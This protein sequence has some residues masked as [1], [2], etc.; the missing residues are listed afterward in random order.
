VQIEHTADV[1]VDAEADSFQGLLEELAQAMFELIVDPGKVRVGREYDVGVISGESREQLALNW[2]NELLYLHEVE[3]AVFSRFSLEMEGSVRAEGKATGEPIDSAR[4]VP[5]GIVKAATYH[6][7]VIEERG[8]V[9]HGR[10]Y[11]DV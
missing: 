7:L 4:H 6:G 8:G 3:E 10:V 5:L 2:L 11:F 9:W 1:G